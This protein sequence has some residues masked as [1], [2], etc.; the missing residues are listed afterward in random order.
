[1][2]AHQTVAE[3]CT[4]MR[5]A[6]LWCFDEW[7]RGHCRAHQL[8]GKASHKVRNA[9]ISKEAMLSLT[10]VSEVPEAEVSKNSLRSPGAAASRARSV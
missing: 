7:L 10:Q 9:S 6:A 3:K 1:M 5:G 4:A 2:A 8:L